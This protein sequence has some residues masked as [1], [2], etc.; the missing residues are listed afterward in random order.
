[1][2]ASTRACSVPPPNLYKIPHSPLPFPLSIPT[3]GSF[4]AELAPCHNLLFRLSPATRVALLACEREAT[5]TG[6][7]GGAALTALLAEMSPQE[8]WAVR[9]NQLVSAVW[10][11]AQHAAATP[12]DGGSDPA[13]AG[14]ATAGECCVFATCSATAGDCCVSGTG[15]ATGSD[16]STVT[17]A[18]A[19][20]DGAEGEP[21]PAKRQR[22]V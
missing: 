17:T 2:V 7:D 22:R 18:T 9:L 14:S 3:L 13:A 20:T 12:R 16:D 10:V 15:S 1:M 21:S 5:C 6:A 11:Q 19:A 4:E 8:A